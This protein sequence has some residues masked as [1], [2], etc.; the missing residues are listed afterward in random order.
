MSAR[1]IP[2]LEPVL[3]GNERAY[4]DQCVASG[5]VSS[6][7]PFVPRFEREFA[8][9]VGAEHAVACASGTAALHLAML[10]VGVGPGDDVLVSDLTFIASANPARY[11]GAR[12]ILVDSEPSGW[13]LDP[14][15]VEAELDRRGRVGLRMPAAIVAVHVFG[16]LAALERILA[17][18]TD[19]GV[20][21]IEDA[22]EAL[23]GHWLSPPFRL[24]Q[25][26][27][28]GEIGV[29]SFNGNKVLTTGGGGMLV[30]ADAAKA[31]KARHLSTQARLPGSDYV[32]DTIG[33]NYRLSN[34][35]AA[36]GLAQL[37]R[38]DAMLARKREIANRY[39]DEFE[40]EPRVETVP[41]A[42]GTRGSAWLCT[43][44]LPSRSDRDRV[45]VALAAEGIETR[46]VWPPLHLQQPYLGSPVLGGGA[47][48]VELAGRG[49]SLPSS[50]GLSDTD[51]TEV[52][53]ALIGA[54]D[55]R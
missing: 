21:V 4:L 26:G 31:A 35:A 49:L 27:T 8:E 22:A 9:R 19:H 36:V 44:L 51:L 6:V 53:D 24:R 52:A 33:F 55:G 5:Q 12:V 47:V 11:C 34:I 18:A 3:L 20:P 29:F 54:L 46:P 43:V 16:Q 28:V 48:A 45:R 7:G 42:P 10:A 25:A 2:L 39:D 37:E 32:H 50:A 15:L 23:G 41:D 13:N 30:T 40:G 14:A 38:L 17:A 1:R